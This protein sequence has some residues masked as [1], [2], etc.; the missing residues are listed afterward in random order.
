MPLNKATLKA[1]I[2]SKVQ[3]KFTIETEQ[4]LDD[5][6]DAVADAVVT[7]IQAAALVSGTVTS[8]AG[9]GGA[10]TGTVS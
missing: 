9:S 3:S 10:V 2:I 5:F 1:L 7:H 8:G 6:A 4:T